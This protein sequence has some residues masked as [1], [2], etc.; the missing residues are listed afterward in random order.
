L[1][2]RKIVL[3]LSDLDRTKSSVLG[4]LSRRQRISSKKII[5]AIR[6]GRKILQS[7]RSEGLVDGGWR[8]VIEVVRNRLQS[9][10]E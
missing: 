4:N 3:R 9:H 10:T 7:F 2:C 1:R 8:E 6:A 5:G